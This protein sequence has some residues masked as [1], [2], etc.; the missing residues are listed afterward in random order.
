MAGDL[1]NIGDIEGACG[2][3]KAALGKCDGDSPP[4][5]FVAGG[6]AASELKAMIIDLMADLGCE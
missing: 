1:I 3:L 4:P 6:P 5:D 2:Q